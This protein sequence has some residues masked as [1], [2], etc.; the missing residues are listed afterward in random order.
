MNLLI[1]ALVLSFL[2]MFY[3]YCITPVIERIKR[4]IRRNRGLIQ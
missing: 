1:T 2:G 4:V 3:G